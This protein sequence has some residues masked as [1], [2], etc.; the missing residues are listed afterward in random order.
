MYKFKDIPSDVIHHIILPM[1]YNNFLN[2]LLL[3]IDCFYE[4][5]KK[6]D[7][8]KYRSTYIQRIPNLK[9]LQFVEKKLYAKVISDKF[10]QKLFDEFYNKH[11]KKAARAFNIIEDKGMI[12]KDEVLNRR[13]YRVECYSDFHGGVSNVVVIHYI[14]HDKL[15]EKHSYKTTKIKFVRV[16]EKN[17]L[18]KV[19]ELPKKNLKDSPHMFHTIDFTESLLNPI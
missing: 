2:E 18:L 12:I 13:H 7:D 4:K 10:D 5:G 14:L 6:E 8:D 15:P 3:Y 16:Y 19:I 11:R 9:V 1:K 17:K